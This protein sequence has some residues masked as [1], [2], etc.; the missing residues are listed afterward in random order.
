MMSGSCV[1][2]E[3]FYRAY[4]ANNSNTHLPVYYRVAATWGAH[5]GSLLL[6][7]LLLSAWTFAVALFSRS[8]PQDAV[9]RVL[10]VMGM[11]NFGFLLFIILTSNPFTRTLPDFPVEGQR[12]EPAVAGYR[13][14]F[15]SS[16]VV[17]GVCRFLRGVCVLLLLR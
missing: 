5:E 13:A 3:R 11:I 4:V 8:M 6:W 17:H 2:G 14:D 9:A 15:P 12:P 16:V 10:A 1:C 7:V